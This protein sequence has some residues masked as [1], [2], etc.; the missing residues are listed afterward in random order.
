MRRLIEDGK[1]RLHRCPLANR[2]F[3]FIRHQIIRKK[4]LIMDDT[5]LLRQC[6]NAPRRVNAKIRPC[7]NRPARIIG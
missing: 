5:A 6:V 2:H 4:F 7:P 1:R 3:V